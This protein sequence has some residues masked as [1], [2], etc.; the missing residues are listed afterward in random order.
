MYFVYALQSYSHPQKI[1]VGYTTDLKQRL[2]KHNSGGSIYTAKFR[3]WK[4]ILSMGFETQ[5]K[6]K[7]FELYLKT[8]SGK[9]FD[10][11]RLW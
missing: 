9:A 7:E 6:A 5:I 4:L 11:K 3:P 1:Y 10:L 2:E 8:P